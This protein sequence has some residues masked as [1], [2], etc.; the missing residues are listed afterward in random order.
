M[1]SKDVLLEKYT[2]FVR[3]FAFAD[4]E[5]DLDSDKELLQ[6]YLDQFAATG[7]DV[8]NINSGHDLIDSLNATIVLL[9]VAILMEN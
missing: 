3:I 1:F 7:M 6:I 5:A 9:K 2:D 4:F 8:S